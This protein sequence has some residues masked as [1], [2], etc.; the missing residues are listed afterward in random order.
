MPRAWACTGELTD[1]LAAV[2]RDR[3]RVR[4]L[5]PGQDLDERGLA[6]PVLADEGVDLACGQVEVHAVEG[7]HAREGL[8][9]PRMDRRRSV[10]DTA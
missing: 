8:E 9:M 3:P 10:S 1:E 4:P 7:L 2:E 6:G 5:D